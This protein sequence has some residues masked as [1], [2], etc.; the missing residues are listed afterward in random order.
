VTQNQKP[1]LHQGS[2]IQCKPEQEILSIFKPNAA[3]GDV[4]GD[5]RALSKDLTKKIM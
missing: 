5:L 4:V 2:E 1:L 3:L